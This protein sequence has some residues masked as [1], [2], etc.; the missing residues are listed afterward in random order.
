[1]YWRHDL[2]DTV[3]PCVSR[4]R[5]WKC[6][7]TPATSAPSAVRTPSSARL[8]V[9]G[10]ARVARRP[11]PVVPTPSRKSSHIF[12]FSMAT[13]AARTGLCTVWWRSMWDE[14]WSII[15]LQHPRRRCHPLHHPS[16]QGNRGGLSVTMGFS[17][18]YVWNKKIAKFKIWKAPKGSSLRIP[19][20]YLE[21]MVLNQ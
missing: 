1:M 6:P 7:S 5:R 10:S 2:T 14:Y 13:G 19:S 11:S 16:S 21:R 18:S 4:W 15:V 17:L 8:L 12:F 3:P 20:H 9:S